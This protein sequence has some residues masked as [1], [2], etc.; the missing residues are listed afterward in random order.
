MKDNQRGIA[1]ALV[2]LT[3]WGFLPIFLKVVVSDISPQTVVWFR[4]CFSF[5]ILF[6]WNLI[7]SPKELRIFHKPPVILL[8]ASACLSWNYFGF[9][10]AVNYTSPS[11]AQL[12]AQVGPLLLALA[13][14]YLFKEKL[15]KIQIAGFIMALLGFA[16]FYQQQV[17]LTSIEEGRYKVGVLFA[18]SGFTTW[19]IYAILQKKLLLQ[20]STGALNTFIFGFASVVYLPFVNFHEFSSLS[21][22]DWMLLVYLGLNTLI[23]YGCLSQ[24]LKYTQANKVS[25]ILLLNP[26]ITFIAMTVLSVMQVSW[27]GKEEF[28][29]LAIVSAL[30]ILLG[31]VFVISKPRKDSQLQN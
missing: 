26:I 3:L 21:F 15:R 29:K 6:L 30:L 28:T 24:A 25:I 4:F 9:M 1:Y 27:I 20:F 12:I 11:N 19:A 13:G 7:R 31:A 5:M 8:A 16:L 23:A 10:Q 17:G 2:T 18:I 14:V 22:G